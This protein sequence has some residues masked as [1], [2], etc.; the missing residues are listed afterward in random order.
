M[1]MMASYFFVSASVRAAEGISKA[2][3]T[4]TSLMSFSFAP[5]RTKPSYALRNSLSVMKELKR[6]TTRAK[7]FPVALRLP[8]MA[9]ILG[10][11]LLS[12]SVAPCL[13]VDFSN[14]CNA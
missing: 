2:P 4:R 3:G 11:P 1:Q 12:F 7:R 10:P 6:D 14:Q 9:L 8:S 5:E 13:H